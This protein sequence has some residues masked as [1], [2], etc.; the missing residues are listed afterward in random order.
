MMLTKCR[1]QYVS[2]FGKHSHGYRT[3]KGQSSSQFSRRAVL[4]NV[5]T[6]RQLYSSATSK[7]MLKIL[8][9]RLHHNGTKNFQMFKLG[10]EK[11]E[12]P[13]IKLAAFIGS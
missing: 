12:E 1:T 4:R 3:G 7:V 11:A 6:T 8:Q 2:Q 5:E 9:A 13:E 10:L